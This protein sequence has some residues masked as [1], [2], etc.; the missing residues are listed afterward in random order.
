TSAGP[1]LPALSTEFTVPLNLNVGDASAG[2]TVERAIV[3]IE[4][5]RVGEKIESKVS[6]RL[7]A[8]GALGPVT[9][10]ADGI[11]AG[12]GNPGGHF[13][14]EAE[15]PNLLGLSL[16]AGPISGGGMLAHIGSDYVGALQLKLLGI[17]VNAFALLGE[18]GGAPSFVGVL[19]IRLPPP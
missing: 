16:E 11:G 12:F 1:G 14:P 19:G 13:A 6:V 2:L 15:P 4:A 10:V 8:R 5:A 18:A 7:G 9:I 17:G 3:R